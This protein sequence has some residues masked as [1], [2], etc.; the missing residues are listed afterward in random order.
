[1]QLR[2]FDGAQETHRNPQLDPISGEAL[3]P[4]EVVGGGGQQ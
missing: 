1:M 2:Q 4:G 3:L